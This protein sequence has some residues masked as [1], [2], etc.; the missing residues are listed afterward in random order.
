[1]KKQL[2]DAKWILCPVC[3]GKTRTKIFEDTKIYFFPLFCPK[4]KHEVIIN[5]KNGN[6]EMC[7]E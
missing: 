7:K 5:V 4:C 2:D 1:M 3:N 6:V